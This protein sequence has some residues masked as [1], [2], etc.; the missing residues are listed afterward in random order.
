MRWTS[1]AAL[2]AVFLATHAA[3]AVAG[4]RAV[5]PLLLRILDDPAAGLAA[6]AGKLGGLPADGRIPCFIRLDSPE[7]D[8]GA[9]LGVAV[10]SAAGRI[11]TARLT[12]DQISRLAGSEGVDGVAMAVR[13]APVLDASVPEISGGEVHD[14]SGFPP[15]YSGIT[16]QG[17]VMGV[18]DTGIDPYHGDFWS[19]G[20]TR[21]LSIWD[22]TAVGTP[23][24]GFSYGREWTSAQIESAACTE[25]DTEGHGTHVAGIAAGNGAGTGNGQVPYRYVGVAPEADII[26]VKT[27]FLTTDIADAVS[28]ILG[29]AAVL[30]R[31]AVVNM[32]LGTQYGPHDG[33]A[34]FDLALSSLA[35]ADRILVAAAGN[36]RGD[37]IHGEQTISQGLA[38]T[39][40]FDVPSYSPAFGSG[41]D[42]VSIDGWYPGGSEIS[43][44]VTSPN[45]HVTGPVGAFSSS[46]N[47][48]ADGFVSVDNAVTSPLN[49]DENIHIEIYDAVSTS[50]PEPGTWEIEIQGASVPSGLFPA[51]AQIDFWIYYATMLPGPA[52]AVGKEE[53]EIVGSPA[54]ADSVIAVGAYVTKNQW[55]SIDGHMYQYNP[56][57]TVGAIA[58]FSSIGPSRDGG[59]KPEIAAPGMGIA[60]TLSSDAV[61]PAVF[62]VT[63]GVHFLTQGT[64]MASPHVAGVAALMLEGLGSL[65]RQE[66]LESFANSARSDGHTGAVPN[67]TWGY[68]KVDALGALA[69]PTAVLISGLEAVAFTWGVAVS[70]ASSGDYSPDGFHVLRAMDTGL[71][72]GGLLAGA[73]VVAFVA[74]TSRFETA[75]D[76]SLEEAG[77]YAYWIRP[78][79]RGEEEPPTGPAYVEWSPGSGSLPRAR[80]PY[81]NPFS[82][83]TVLSFELPAPAEV[84]VEILDPSG[85]RIRRLGGGTFPAGEHGLAWDGTSDAGRPAASGLYFARI[86]SGRFERTSRL[87]LLR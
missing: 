47:P 77:R 60:S 82:P 25:E 49:G 61:Q 37:G 35:G 74:R 16:G 15:S 43:V 79:F 71:D 3:S 69:G 33:T 65:S 34:D 12:P 72:A 55:S 23:P 9:R 6:A 14:G 51:G 29:K 10:E 76:R 87:M 86:V 54:S 38:A 18:I 81:P 41:N 84:V 68:G 32:S 64:S 53:A 21:I 80:D 67:A 83:E 2:T 26:A 19:G 20:Q 45:G 48:T 5:D 52:F 85:R 7:A 39:V 24:A 50:A 17:I 75:E 58:F 63:D 78:L 13:A 40:T 57:A 66:M 11:V 70:W 4:A 31:P 46:G 36:E 56:P 62:T 8:P 22:Q 1:S 44:V 27:S 59:L 28:Y 73:E 42:F 30:G